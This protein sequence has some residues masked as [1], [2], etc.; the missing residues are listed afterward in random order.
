MA[1]KKKWI[2]PVSEKPYKL[3]KRNQCIAS[4]LG[5]KYNCTV[6]EVTNKHNYKLQTN[7]GTIFANVTWGSLLTEYKPWYIIK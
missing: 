1:K 5:T 4:F 6:L 3:K 7:T 2:K